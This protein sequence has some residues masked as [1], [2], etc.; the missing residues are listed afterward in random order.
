M[1]IL[2]YKAEEVSSTAVL[3]RENSVT[4]IWSAAYVGI[5]QLTR[6]NPC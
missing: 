3:F 5:L 6:R 2:E 1:K 4:S